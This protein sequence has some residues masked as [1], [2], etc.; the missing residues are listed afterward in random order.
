MKFLMGRLLDNPADGVSMEELKQATG[1]KE[2][3]IR[4]A[5]QMRLPDVH[6][7]NKKL[8]LREGTAVGR[9]RFEQSAEFIEQQINPRS[10]R[11]KE[12]G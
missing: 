3:S 5:V 10:G 6:W 9:D 1:L 12:K 7:D 11:S 4:N 2:S 8:K